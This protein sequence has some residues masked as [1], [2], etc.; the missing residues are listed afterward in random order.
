MIVAVVLISEVLA[1]VGLLVGGLLGFAVVLWTQ[2]MASAL[3]IISFGYYALVGLMPVVLWFVLDWTNDHEDYRAAYA[4]P[5]SGILT[6]LQGALLGG[7]L[8]AGPVFLALVITLPSL[9]GNFNLSEFG[10]A[11][12][13]EIVWSQLSIAIAAVVISAIP[14][15]L[16]SYYTKAG[17]EN[18]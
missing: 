4:S 15:G 16:W 17:Q 9:L 1:A 12:W 2:D 11:V 3:R 7:V 5:F 8:G 13:D 10:P 6:A 14:L 18:D